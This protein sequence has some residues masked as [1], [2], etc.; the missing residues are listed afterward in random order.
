[1]T[2]EQSDDRSYP[3]KPIPISIALVVAAIFWM[4]G[5]PPVWWPS[6]IPAYAVLPLVFVIVLGLLEFIHDM[7]N[8]PGADVNE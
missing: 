4:K 7:R 2:S 6:F 3:F 1:M 5:T 8:L